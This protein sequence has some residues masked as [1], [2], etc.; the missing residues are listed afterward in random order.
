MIEMFV[1]LMHLKHQA[2]IGL[3]VYAG[4]TMVRVTD[5]GR[6]RCKGWH[7]WCI[8]AAHTIVIGLCIFIQCML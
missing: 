7:E 5:A 1:V 6:L 8:V 4:G 2:T 3:C